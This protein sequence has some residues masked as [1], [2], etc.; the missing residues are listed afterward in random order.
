MKYKII[1]PLL[2]VVLLSSCQAS[3]LIED[4]IYA[5]DTFI[6]V[7]LFEGNEDDKTYL[8]N[9]IT[10]YASYSDNYK[11]IANINNIYTINSTNEEVEVD[12]RL[13]L[14]LKTAFTYSDFNADNFNPLCGS[15]SNKWKEALKDNHVPDETT[16]N[17]ELNK[18]NNSSLLFKDNDIVQ[19]V[20][21]AELD[22][23]G[24]AKGYVLDE[25]L[26]YLAL[27]GYKHYLIN[28]GSSSILLGE[29]D[30]KDGYFTVGIKDNV[31]PSSYLKLKNCFVSTSSISEQGVKIGD[32]TY[33]HI[34]DPHTGSAINKQES[35]IVV[36][37]KGYVG[38]ILSTSLMNNTLDEIK[39][40]EKAQ[41]FK[42]IVINNKTIT[43]KSE[44]LEVY[45]K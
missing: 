45:K 42:C 33:S 1:S 10:D 34:I 28:G 5:F 15:L 44:G 29:K 25:A 43:Y 4:N 41:G 16:I 14:M 8:H 23:G 37:D 26:G 36:T 20:G 24:V 6:D 9:L 13:Y 18:I 19:R 21:E 7:K 17:N 38:D 11:A 2:L 30:N 39:E 27:H 12:H 32:V 40:I 35:I 22:L 31:L 3:T